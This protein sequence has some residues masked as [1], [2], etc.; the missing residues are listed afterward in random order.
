[1]R[2]TKL[3]G[4]GTD[5]RLPDDKGKLVY[6]RPKKKGFSSCAAQGAKKN[7]VQYFG[8]AADEP[9]RIARHT[10]AGIRLPLVEIGWEE[11]YCGLWCQCA[12]LLSPVYTTATRGGC[13]FCHNQGV[14][15]LRMLRQ[16][17]PEYWKLLLKWDADS[18]VSFHADGHTVHDFDSRFALEDAGILLPGD[19]TFK[20]SMLT[21]DVQMKWF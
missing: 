4:G 16:M 5:T 14:D 20:W 19:S 9:E 1:M 13:W 8:I 7:T 18:P 2:S 15:Q 17:Y 11:S 21:G 6:Q 12:G 10:K 3:R